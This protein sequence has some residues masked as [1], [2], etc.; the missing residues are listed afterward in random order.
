MTVLL[1]F[2]YLII[3]MFLSR[4]GVDFKKQ[5]STLLSKIVIPLVIIYNIFASEHDFFVIIVASFLIMAFM[6]Q[7]AKRLTKDPVEELCFC[8]LNIGWLALPLA[9]AIFGNEPASVILAFY[10][11][12]SIQAN[13]ASVT[14]FSSKLTWQ[15]KVVKLLKAPHIWAILVGITLIPFK[16]PL[17]QM[18]LWPYIGMKF[19]MS[20]LGMMILGAWLINTKLN[21]DDV[22]RSFYFFWM[23]TLALAFFITGLILFSYWQSIDLITRNIAVLYLLCFLPPA[24]YVVVLETQFLKTGKSAKIIASSTLISFVLLA[25]YIGALVYFECI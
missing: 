3:G 13:L 18:T 21:W 2:L 5:A 11:G 25:L 20:A 7:L 22:K 16:E 24:A 6:L 19:L 23:R 17:M 1:P 15:S 14:L 4:M 10:V 9:H 12:S 8:Y